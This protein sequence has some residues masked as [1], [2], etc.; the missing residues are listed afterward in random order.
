MK[1]VSAV[2]AMV[3]LLGGCELMAP[4][5]QP[6]APPAPAPAIAAAPPVVVSPVPTTPPPAPAVAAAPASAPPPLPPPVPFAQAVQAAANNLFSNAPLNPGSRQPV[7]IDPLIDGVSGME[8]IATRAMEDRL[9]ELMKSRYTAL[10]L[11]PFSAATVRRAPWVL[12]GTFTPI[13]AAGQAAGAKDA[14]RVCLALADLATGKIVAK[15]FARALQ[16]GVDITPTR[17][18]QDSPAWQAEKLTD[19]Y[20]RTCQGTKAGD[21]INPVYLDG[22]LASS[23]IAEGIA[24][25]Q[26]GRYR[27]ALEFYRAALAMPQGRQLR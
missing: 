27:E 19:G 22:I 5:R 26:T 13:N 21:P 6:P 18:Y 16:D 20:V 11:Q 14:Y 3:F 25:Y 15:G 23:Q 8:S 4:T 1:I 7:V 17:F 9:V 2:A 24:A 10:D 12:I